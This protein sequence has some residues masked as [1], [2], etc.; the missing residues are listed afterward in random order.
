M[1][2]IDFDALRTFDPAFRMAEA[3]AR[4]NGLTQIKIRHWHRR[5]GGTTHII[6]HEPGEGMIMTYKVTVGV[7][8]KRGRRA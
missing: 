6:F 8:R 2:D 1:M 7:K 5:R 4:N 3:I